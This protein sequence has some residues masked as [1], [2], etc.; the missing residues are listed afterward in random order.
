MGNTK[1]AKFQCQKDP[2]SSKRRKY[3]GNQRSAGSS[4]SS[5]VDSLAY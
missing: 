4:C 1:D 2:R 3:Y 5:Q